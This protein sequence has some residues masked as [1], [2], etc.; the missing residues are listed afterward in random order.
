MLLPDPAVGI[1]EIPADFLPGHEGEITLLQ[2]QAL[3]RVA[4]HSP[5][6]LSSVQPS[7]DAL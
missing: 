3:G 2:D 4:L 6:P 7:A 1:I 5:T